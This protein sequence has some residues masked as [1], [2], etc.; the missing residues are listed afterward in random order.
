M[1]AISQFLLIGTTHANHSRISGKFSTFINSSWVQNIFCSSTGNGSECNERYGFSLPRSSHHPNTDHWHSRNVTWLHEKNLSLTIEPDEITESPRHY[2]SYLASCVHWVKAMSS[3]L[4]QC[5]WW[6]RGSNNGSFFPPS[7]VW[8]MEK[9][10]KLIWIPLINRWKGCHRSSGNQYRIFSSRSSGGAA[11]DTEDSSETRYSWLNRQNMV[12][13]AHLL[14]PFSLPLRLTSDQYTYLVFISLFGI[15]YNTQDKSV[16]L[17]YSSSIISNRLR[18]DYDSTKDEVKAYAYSP[19]NDKWSQSVQV[20][21]GEHVE[22]EKWWPWSKNLMKR[23]RSFLQEI[24]GQN[25]RNEQKGAIS[26]S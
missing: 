4:I 14:N 16:L 3:F 6:N 11:A 18:F 10:K 24:N 25:P 26:T 9:G 20:F 15:L 19:M 7:S 2:C 5:E 22:V 1:T 12:I 17:A 8:T 21:V 23:N 13:D